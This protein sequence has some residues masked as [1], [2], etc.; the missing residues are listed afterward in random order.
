MTEESRERFPV[1]AEIIIFFFKLP[2]S[3]EA[4]TAFYP[5]GTRD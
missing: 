1:G 5:M 4:Q 3:S 2:A